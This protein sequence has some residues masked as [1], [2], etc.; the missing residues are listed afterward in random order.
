VEPLAAAFASTLG[1]VI[2]LAAWLVRWIVRTLRAGYDE[3]VADIRAHNAETV[4]ILKTQ[5]E[6]GRSLAT[7]LDAIQHGQETTQRLIEAMT[8]RV[9]GAA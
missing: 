4:D 3:R 1:A 6:T 9:R 2:A 8:E 5:I 7:S